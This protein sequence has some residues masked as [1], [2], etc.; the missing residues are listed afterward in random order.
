MKKIVTYLRPYLPA[1]VVVFVLVFVQALADLRLPSLMAGIVDRGVRHG[2]TAI[3][4]RTGAQMLVVALVGAACSLG[5][6]LL[7]ARTSAALGRDLR[8]RV[9]AHVESFSLHEFDSLGTASLITRTTNDVW[10]VQTVTLVLMRMVIG[11][12]VMAGG[13]VIMAVA[14]DARLSWIFAVV[15]PLTAA[16]VA[17][18]A[19]VA[20]PLFREMQRRLD[21]VNLIVREGLTGVRVIRAFDRGAAQAERFDQANRDLTATA[22]RVSRIMAALMPILMVLLNLSTVAIVRF[23]ALRVSAG[24]LQVGHLMAFLQYAMQIL[25]SFVM[26]SMIFVMLPR[27]AASAVRI[28]EV[29]ARTATVSDPATPRQ[30][31]ARGTVEFEQVSFAYPGAEEPAVR[32]VSFAARPDEVTAIIGG[33]GSGKSTLLGLVPRFYD[34]CSGRVLVD[35]VDVRELAQEDLRAR[36]GFV[37]QKAVLFSGTIA[38]NIRAGKDDASDEEIADAA[39]TAQAEEFIAALP[40]GFATRIAEGGTDLSGGQKQRLA[41]ARA[42]VRR[43]CIYILDDSFSALDFKTDARLRAAL[44]HE[45]AAATVLLVAQRVG[46]VMDADRIIVLDEGRVAGVGRHE[47]LLASCPLYREVVASQLGEEVLA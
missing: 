16:V 38:D 24:T 36:I 3:I 14:T 4:W 23:G 9:F 1:V 40:D 10:Q 31:P 8:R 26:L 12:P 30:V 43:P 13:G 46:S 15:L 34:A 41:I 37:P 11:A 47:E 42:L 25:W 2:D 35:G 33:T 20:V 21:R 32:A 28:D 22:L 19:R 7:S 45:T 18:V 29:L 44:R 6:T 27:A 17:L 39:R 5:A